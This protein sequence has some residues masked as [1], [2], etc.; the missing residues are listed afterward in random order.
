MSLYFDK[1]N[2]ELAGVPGEAAPAPAWFLSVIVGGIFLIIWG[3]VIAIVVRQK[4]L[5]KRTKI[6]IV[7]VVSAVMLLIGIFLVWYFYF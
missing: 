5:E 1:Q 6:I 7:S 3:S 4:K 2:D